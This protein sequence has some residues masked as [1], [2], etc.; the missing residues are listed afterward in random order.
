MTAAPPAPQIGDIH[1]TPTEEEM[2]AIVAAIEMT[3]PRPAAPTSAVVDD[4]D[5]GV[6][7]LGSL[8]GASGRRAPRPPVVAGREE[9]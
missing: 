2:A 7:V 8:V 9:P 5:P 3:W 4:T 6:A 1:P